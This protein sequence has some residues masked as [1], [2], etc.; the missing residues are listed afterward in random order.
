MSLR[1]P[2]AETIVFLQKLL[3]NAL[4]DV[5]PGPPSL[6]DPTANLVLDSYRYPFNVQQQ[7]LVLVMGYDDRSFR[8]KFPLSG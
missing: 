4:R 2:Q 3:H 6:S 1:L 7:L 5:F 8:R